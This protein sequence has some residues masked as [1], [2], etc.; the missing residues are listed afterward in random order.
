M[1][2][3][4]GV[5]YTRDQIGDKLGGSKRAYLP[6]VND[7][8]TCGCF[9]PEHVNPDAPEEVLFGRPDHSPEINRSADLVFQQ[10]CKGIDIPIFLKRRVNA[11]EYVGQFLCIGITRDRR[12]VRRKLEC[13]PERGDFSGVLRFE[14]M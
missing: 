4:L 6:N 7:L 11:W 9:E 1:P 8:V 12:V 14:R 3:E 2:F 13:Y 5:L 10:G